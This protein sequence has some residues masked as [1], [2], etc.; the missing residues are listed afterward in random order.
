M[1]H[2]AE[3]LQDWLDIMANRPLEASVVSSNSSPAQFA[4]HPKSTSIMLRGSPDMK[5]RSSACMASMC[6]LVNLLRKERGRPLR[7][8]PSCRGSSCGC[9]TGE[10]RSALPFVPSTSDEG[11]GGRRGPDQLEEADPPSLSL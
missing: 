1:L 4:Q 5:A 9:R 6:T 7:P 2:N 10:G 3:H 8:P 11:G